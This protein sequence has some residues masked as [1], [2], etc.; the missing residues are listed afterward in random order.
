MKIL[1]ATDGSEYSFATARKCCEM[2]ALDEDSTIKISSI[3]A[4]I[5]SSMQFEDSDGYLVI[6]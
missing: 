2:I 4:M 3:G 6:A 1:L 5:I